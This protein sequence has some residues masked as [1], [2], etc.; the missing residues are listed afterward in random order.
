MV[1]AKYVA[2]TNLTLGRV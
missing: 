1:I 2:F